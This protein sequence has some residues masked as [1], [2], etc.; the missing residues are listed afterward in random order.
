[1]VLFLKQWSDS[2]KYGVGRV[3]NFFKKVFFYLF[4][5]RLY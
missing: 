4:R 1:M 3:K 5:Q 2:V